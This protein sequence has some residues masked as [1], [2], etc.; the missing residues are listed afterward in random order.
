MRVGHGPVP[1][2][3]PDDNARQRAVFLHELRHAV[4]KLLVIHRQTL[5]FVQRN[6]RSLQEQLVL[7]LQWQGKTVDDGP[8]DL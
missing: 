2:Q 5:W 3:A 8:Q 7:L 6:Q 4:G 1:E